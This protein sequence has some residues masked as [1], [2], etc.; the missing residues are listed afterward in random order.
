MRKSDFIWLISSIRTSASIVDRYALAFS[1]ARP[2]WLTMAEAMALGKP[3]IAT[4]Y[5]GN[6]QFMTEANSF[7]VP[8]TPATIPAGCDPYPSGGTWADPDLEGAAR[9][10]RTVL[11]DP[12]LAA[13]RGRQGAEDLRTLHSPQAAGRVVSARLAEI[14]AERPT[15]RRPGP[16]HHLRAIARRTLGG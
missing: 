11:E 15:P 7:L 14:D 10:M 16:S 13:A 12:D 6:L 5:S 3:V 9:L 8:W 1:M 4:G 2:S